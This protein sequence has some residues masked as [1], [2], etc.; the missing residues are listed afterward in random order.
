[1]PASAIHSHS[2]AILMI[3]P[4]WPKKKGGIRAVRPNQERLL[5]YTTMDISEIFQLLDT[6][7]FPLASA[8]HTVFLWGIDQFLHDGELEMEKRGYR[9]HARFI[10]DK[11]NG[12]APAFSVRYTHEYLT[13]FYKPKFMQVADNV[14]GKY[15]TVLTEKAREHSR[16]PEAAYNMIEAMYPDE[17]KLDVFSRQIRQNWDSYGNQVGYY[18]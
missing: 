10:W 18:K 8:I 17:S 1:M 4:P 14:R 3:D 2:Y 16:K 11:L 12:V 15:T 7:I 5:D 9:R 13:W 6:D